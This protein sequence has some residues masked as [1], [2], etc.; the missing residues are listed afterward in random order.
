MKRSSSSQEELLL[1]LDKVKLV[2]RKRDN[3]NKQVR[4][5]ESEAVR[6]ENELSTVQVAFETFKTSANAELSTTLVQADKT[7]SDLSRKLSERK[8]LLRKF[9]SEIKRLQKEIGNYKVLVGKYKS[10]KG[11]NEVR[12]I[13]K[14]L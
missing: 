7:I 3:V 4:R 11:G 1:S 12:M 2:P 8:K 10:N 13:V 5:V 6:N 9:N 14:M